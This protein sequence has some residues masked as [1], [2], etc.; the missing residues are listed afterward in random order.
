MRIFRFFLGYVVGIG[1]FTVLIPASLFY[2]SRVNVFPF[3]ASIFSNQMIPD[4]IAG[5][6]FIIGVVFIIWSNL[7]LFQRGKGGPVD[8]AGISVSPQTQKLVTD[9]PYRYTRNPMVFGANAVYLALV[10][11]FNS[12][13]TFLIWLLFYNIPVRFA[14]YKEEE[15]LLQDFQEEYIRYRAATPRMIPSPIREKQKEE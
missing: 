15:R 4:L 14:I 2:L 10:I 11:Y 9:G 8:F 13:G 6:I 1:I 3:S 12:W 5:P 7:F